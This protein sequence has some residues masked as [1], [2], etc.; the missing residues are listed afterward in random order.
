MT[1][2]VDETRADELPS[3]INDFRFL[4]RDYVRCNFG[5]DSPLDE[6]I[7]WWEAHILF[8]VEE[9][10][11]PTTNERRLSHLKITPGGYCC[12]EQDFKMRLKIGMRHNCKEA[13]L[14]R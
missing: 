9:E 7:K 4:P 3:C 6:D 14:Y 10:Y 8:F 1:V 11:T 2:T 12:L 5:Y 13:L